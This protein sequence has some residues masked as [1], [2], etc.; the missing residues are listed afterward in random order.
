MLDK[1]PPMGS[2]AAETLD[3]QYHRPDLLKVKFMIQELADQLYDFGS[4][5]SDVASRSSSGED[6][7]EEISGKGGFQRRRKES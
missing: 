5:M 4:C 6:S 7:L 2:L 3:S 1:T